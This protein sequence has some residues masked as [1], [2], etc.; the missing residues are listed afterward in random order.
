M[1]LPK[2]GQPPELTQLA[3]ELLDDEVEDGALTLS[4]LRDLNIN[5]GTHDHAW[6]EGVHACKIEFHVGDIGYVPKDFDTSEGGTR[7]NNFVKLGNIYECGREG[8]EDEDKIDSTVPSPEMQVVREAIGSQSQW[9]NRFIQR[10]ESHPFQFPGDIEGSVLSTC[11]FPRGLLT[12]VF[13]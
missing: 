13:W 11:D 5:A 6:H 12:F 1:L 7:F 2:R 3:E 10:S 8:N 4:R 9:V